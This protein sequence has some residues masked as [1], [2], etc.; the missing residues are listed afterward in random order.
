[1]NS[2]SELESEL[3]LGAIDIVE[4]FTSL[5][6]ELKLQVRSGRDLQ[7]ALDGRLQ[8]IEQRLD[9]Q[10][11]LV[12]RIESTPP[13][14]P[15]S[16]TVGG[17]QRLLAE[18][19]QLAEALAEIEE[20]LQRAAETLAAPLVAKGQPSAPANPLAELLVQFDQSIAAASW[21]SKLLARPL[22][23]RLRGLIEGSLREPTIA[24]ADPARERLEVS[25]RGLELLLQRVHRLMEGCNV[26]RHDVLGQAFDAETMR[27]VDVVSTDAVPSSHVAEQL[28]PLYLW[29]GQVLKYANVRLA[30]ESA[31][32]LWSAK[33]KT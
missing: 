16:A 13:A 7:Q 17:D 29:Q 10:I 9:E 24:V 6:H 8:Q 2:D 27:S 12:S 25:G 15:A 30:K 3:L 21:T 4:A 23:A 22:L 31:M 14:P 20:N 11:A 1:M 32:H 28:R 5:R 19:R 33:V 18:S 26:E